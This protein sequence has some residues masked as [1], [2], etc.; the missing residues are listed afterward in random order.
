[1]QFNEFEPMTIVSKEHVH[2]EGCDNGD[3]K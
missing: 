1:M 2:C 3:E